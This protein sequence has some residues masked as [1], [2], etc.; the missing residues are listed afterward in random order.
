ME[1][2]QFIRLV[3][4]V[5]TDGKLTS[6]VLACLQPDGG[7]EILSGHH[8]TEAAIEVGLT[9][10]DVI[11]VTTPLTEARKTAIQLSHN[12]V[13]GQDNPSILAALYDS[14]DLDAK[15]FSGLTDDILKGF[16]DLQS[17]SLTSMQTSYEE[18]VLSF[19]PEEKDAL[20]RNVE[21]LRAHLKKRPILAARHADFDAVFDTIVRVKHSLNIINTAM[22]VAMMA[23]LANERLDQRENVPE[24]TSGDPSR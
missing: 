23:E 20:E 18:I 22:A 4:N 1:P 21:K 5:R 16:G 11:V 15:K 8:R 17:M 6:A 10:V 14:L 3:E 9:E 13:E 19:L 12:A 2:A 7:L 24:D